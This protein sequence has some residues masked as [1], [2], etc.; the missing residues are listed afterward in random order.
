MSSNPKEVINL[1]AFYES[2]LNDYKNGM[3]RYPL[4]NLPEGEYTLELKSWNLQNV[5][6]TASIHFVV[7]KGLKPTIEEFSIFP[8]PIK[9]EATLTVAYDRPGDNTQI[10]FFIYDLVGQCHWQSGQ[11]VKTTDGKY[12]ATWHVNTQNGIYLKPGLY[13]ATV[14][15]TTSEGTFMQ[16]T[17]KIMVVSQ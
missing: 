17:K 16:N 15:V 8:N 6:S 4:G 10:E 3:I 9:E 14:R 1:N 12:T 5:S 11:A 2:S 13:L 7:E